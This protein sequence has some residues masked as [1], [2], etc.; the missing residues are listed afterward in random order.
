MSAIYLPIVLMI[1]LAVYFVTGNPLSAVAVLVVACACAI[2]IAT[3]VVVIASVGLAGRRGVLIKGG[4]TL[5]NLAKVDTLVLDKTGTLTEGR[6]RLAEVMSFDGTSEAEL[7]RAVASV[8][9]RS[10][11]PIARAVVDAAET[12]GIQPTDPDS[13]ESLTGADRPAML[14]WLQARRGRDGLGSAMGYRQSEPAGG[15]KRQAHA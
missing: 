2:V 8:E 13:F 3:P 4:L 9:S 5:E 12:R 10:S 6:P 11:H 14:Y 7:L 15:A 1:A